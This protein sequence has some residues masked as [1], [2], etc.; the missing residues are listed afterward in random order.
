MANKH[1]LKLT[2]TEAVLKLYT[3]SPT[4]NTIDISLQTD[5]T[6][7]GQTW[8]GNAH[9]GIQ[10]IAWGAKKDKEIDITRIITPANNE[11]HGHYYL[12]NAGVM[13]FNGQGFVDDVYAS[14]DI[15]VTLDGEGHVIIKLR[16]QHG[17]TR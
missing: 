14:K 5:L 7:N 6:A 8:V 15:R 17:W 16:K 11:V 10:Y 1:I 9:V 3:T 12:I 13:D 2:D 4:G